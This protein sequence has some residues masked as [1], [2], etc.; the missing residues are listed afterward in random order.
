MSAQMPRIGNHRW[1]LEED[2]RLKAMVS[3][4][5]SAIGA[6]AAFNRSIG[7]IRIQA[8]KL[9]TPFPSLREVRK[10][11]TDAAPRIGR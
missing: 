11:W 3:D 7:S 4:G 9:G 8:R 10:N 2:Q 6:A 5:K 1:T